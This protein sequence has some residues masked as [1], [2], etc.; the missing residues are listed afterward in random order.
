MPC[1]HCLFLPLGSLADE[2]AHF[3]HSVSLHRSTQ[4]TVIG[5]QALS[6]YAAAVFDRD[7]DLQ[8][9]A[10]AAGAPAVASFSVTTG[11]FDL[12]QQSSVLA[13]GENVT[14]TLSGTGQ[15]LVQ[16]ATAYNVYTDP[17]PAS[18]AVTTNVT[19]VTATLWHLQVCVARLPAAP[20]AAA[21]GAMV[22][23]EVGVFSGWQP[24]QSSLDALQ[25][26]SSG[27]VK[28][29][30]QNGQTVQMYLSELP[31]LQTCLSFDITQAYTVTGLADAAVVAYSYYAPDETGSAKVPALRAA[32]LQPA[33]APVPSTVTVGGAAP[34]PGPV[35]PVSCGTRL[36]QPHSVFMHC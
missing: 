35:S 33:G 23:V 27:L 13:A 18:F 28:L 30:E 4:D 5:L 31:K 8:I 3:L 7:V 21:G 2:H 19:A 26:S 6:R 17:K 24:V 32:A 15:A 20:A 9:S 14:V 1:V 36:P 16:L 22:M 25:A 10:Q 29:I 11:N 34:A 12:L